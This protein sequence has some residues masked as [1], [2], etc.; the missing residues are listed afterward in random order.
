MIL[1]MDLESRSRVD[2]RGCG[3]YV[4]AADPST[5]IMCFAFKIDQEEPLLWV[6]EKFKR[7]LAGSPLSTTT[8]EVFIQ[9]VN[10]ADEIE[11][12]NAGFEA[13]MWQEIMVQRYGFPALP[14]DKIR[15]S[16][17]KAA[18]Y[19]LP[20]SLDG[21]GKALELDVKK[22]T[23]GYRI[24]MKMCKPNRAGAWNEDPKDF[25]KL[26]VYCIRD[27]DTEH[28]A[29][30]RLIELPEEELNTWRLDQIIN[31]RGI[32]V[33]VSAIN[34]LIA[35]VAKKE[36]SLLLEVQAI[37]GGV[38]NSVKQVQ[39]TRAWLKEQGLELKDL[40]KGTVSNALEKN[41]PPKV[42]RLLEI[43]QSLSKSSVS[44][45]K[46]MANRANEDQRVRGTLMYHGA[47]TGRWSGK[48]MQPHNYP[49]DSYGDK[50]ISDILTLDNP[51]VEM[52]YGCP[53][54]NA[55]KCLRGMITA[56]QGGDLICAD[57]SSIEGRV[58]AWIANEELVLSG[59]RKGKDTYKI[60]AA[61][62]YG[63]KYEDINKDERQV[64][65]VI[66]L[67]CGYQGYVGAFKAMASSYGVSYPKE[68]KVELIGKAEARRD[69]KKV[70]PITEDEIFEAWAG[71]LIMTW[72]SSR[73]NTV[74]YW[75]G[76][77]HA[78]LS[79]VKN[80][81]D[82]KVYSYGRIKFGI[83]GGFLHCRLPNG[84]LLS[85]YAPAPTT[86]KT[87]YGV[88][89]E[90]ISFM[91]VDSYTGKWTRLKTYGGKLTENI[92]QA[93]AR[94]LLVEAMHRV[95]AAGYPIVLH[96]HDEIV[97][98]IPE[99][100][101][102]LKEFEDLMSIVPAWAKGCPIGAEGWIGKRYRK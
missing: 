39:A 22:D 73:L 80:R 60:A 33:D 3:M 88:E 50:E 84:R 23:T 78:A 7:L 42:R 75:K 25:E 26:C 47:T 27:V 76:I 38:V 14:F 35:K 100:T 8:D 9:A 30:S 13:I 69:K 43:R 72:R 20:R 52:L 29:S 1:T 37:T 5:D 53:I 71:P 40:S 58:L 99:G 67:A 81:G 97:A 66:E 19:A 18:Y 46:S 16:A 41:I 93:I 28:A 10:S 90:V 24:M 17:A 61:P 56:P 92:V 21:L 44:K 2:L 51:M 89:K 96:V 45:L 91:G 86:T 59:Y 36:S 32:Y 77:E 83:R 54:K 64:G 95:E 94:D 34:N 55:S 98:E 11:A 6:P 31:N 68:Q 79:A 101:G 82:K 65:K 102:N 12:H 49:R 62:I 74:D 87:K 15:C 70:G 4:Y 63:K 48:G 57:F 85:Y